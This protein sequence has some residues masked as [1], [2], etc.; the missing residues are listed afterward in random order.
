MVGHCDRYQ[1]LFG[2]FFVV[3]FRVFWPCSLP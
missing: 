2:R 1:G 3:T